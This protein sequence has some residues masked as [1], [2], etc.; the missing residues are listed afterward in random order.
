MT[1]NMSLRDRAALLQRRAGVADGHAHLALVDE[2][3]SRVVP[4]LPYAD[5]VR[6]GPS[7]P[8]RPH[9]RTS[10]P[11]AG[12]SR[13]GTGLQT[14]EPVWMRQSPTSPASQAHLA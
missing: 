4:P 2:V 10:T 7:A 14:R 12:A 9:S 8:V 1:D 6:R 3:V 13:P 5:G 11:L